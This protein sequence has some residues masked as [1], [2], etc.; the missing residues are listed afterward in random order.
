M[1]LDATGYAGQSGL[2]SF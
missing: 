2:L 1:Q